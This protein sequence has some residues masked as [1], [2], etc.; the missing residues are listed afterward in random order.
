MT[1]TVPLL[2]I[3]YEFFAQDGGEQGQLRMP[4]V[5]KCLHAISSKESRV[6]E[7]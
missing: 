3:K 6:S 2:N 4:V 7:E 1:D 5:I